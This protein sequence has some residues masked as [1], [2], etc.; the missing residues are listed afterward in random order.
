MSKHPL[1]DKWDQAFA[2]PGEAVPIGEQ[3]VCDICNRDLTNSAESGG[4]IFGSNGYCPACA[5]KAMP[6]IRRYN[7]EHHVRARCPAGQ[8]FAD[9]IRAY[10]GPNAV[11]KVTA[12]PPRGRAP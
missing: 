9:F 10:R 2:N 6:D 1:A 7:E 8:S 12:G 3:V 11:I 4:F 5:G